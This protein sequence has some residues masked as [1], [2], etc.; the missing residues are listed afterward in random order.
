[1]EGYANAMNAAANG[2]AEGFVLANSIRD[3]YPALKKVHFIAHSAGTWVVEQASR[4][5]A[6][7]NP[8]VRIQITFLDP[9]IPDADREVPLTWGFPETGMN[10]QRISDLES[11]IGTSRIHILE[12]YFTKDISGYSTEQAFLW[13][14]SGTNFEYNPNGLG[15]PG[16]GHSAPIVFYTNTV[17]FT[18][19]PYPVS[20]NGIDPTIVGWQKSM[21]FTEVAFSEQPV[22][23]SL[24]AGQTAIFSAT[25]FQRGRP[26]RPQSDFNYQWQQFAGG[27]WSN[28]YG[29]Q[30][31]I[32]VPTSDP[33][34][35]GRL[36]RVKATVGGETS[37]SR[38]VRLSLTN[39]T[40]A[41]PPATP[42]NL[43]ASA[44][45]SSQINLS[46]TDTASNESGFRIER[47]LLPSG[48]WDPITTRGSNTTAY[49]DAGLP[50][51][52][53]YEYRVRAY[54][55]YGPSSW[56]N[57]ATARTRLAPT[58]THL[59]SVNAVDLT[60]LQALSVNVYSW[61]GTSTDFRS[62]TTSFSRSAQS[63]KQ[64]TTSAP[65]TLNGG[66]IFQ[67]WLRDGSSRIYNT[68][69]TIT[70]D[71]QHD[72]IAIYG[73]T[74]PANRTLQSISI[75]GPSSI[76]ERRAATYS[77]RATYTDGT[78]GT[79][80]A[81]WSENSSY[82]S[83]S[84]SGVLDT[85]SVSS[86]KGVTVSASATVSGVTRTDTKSVTIRN[87][88]TKPTYTL[89][90]NAV[91]G[92]ISAS[93]DLRSYEEGT[94]VRLTAYPD[95]DYVRSHW[96]GDASG[97]ERS[98][99]IRMTRDK[100]VTA[101]FV[102]DTRRGAVQVGLS[103]PL[104]VAQGAQWK[105]SG[106]VSSTNWQPDGDTFGELPPSSYTI[107]FKPLAGWV[108]PDDQ[109]VEIAG[110]PPAIVSGTYREIPGAVQVMITP[111]AA[112]SAGA[113][114][115]MDGGSWRESGT[116]LSGVVPG[117][118]LIEYSPVAGWS[119]PSARNVSITRG[120]ALSE[121]GDYGPP[122]GL[123][124]ITSI[125]PGTGPIEGG[126][127]IVIEGANFQPDTTV[128]FGGLPAT[129]VTVSSSSLLTAVT[130]PR[131]SY[132]TVPILVTSGG[133]TATRA[134]GFT[135]AIPLGQNMTLVSQI[136]GQ[137]N[138][139]AL[140]GNH[141]VYGEGSSLALADVSN[142]ASPVPRGRIALP[143]TVWGVAI[144]GNYAVAA[145]SKWGIQVIDISDVN[146]PS[147]VGYYDLPGE[148]VDVAVID[149]L[150]YVATSQGGVQVVD[151]TDKVAPVKVGDF[152]QAVGATKLVLT[153]VGG[154]RLACVASG[155]LGTLILNVTNP[156]AITQVSQIASTDARAVAISGGALFARKA[157]DGLNGI[158]RHDLSNPSSPQPT[159]APVY[160]SGDQ[161]LFADGHL[162]L[163]GG[164]LYIQ[165][166]LNPF[167]PV[168]TGYADFPGSTQSMALAGNVLFLAN[169]SGGL[170]V[171]SV[172][173]KASP[174]QVSSL[175]GDIAPEDLVI[176]NGYAYLAQGNLAVIDVAEPQRPTRIGVFG[177]SK[178]VAEL[179]KS[180][181]HL[182]AASGGFGGAPTLS[183]ANPQN[184]A[185]LAVHSSSPSRDSND[186]AVIGSN[187]LVAGK[188]RSADGGQAGLWLYNGSTPTNLTP[189]STIEG[190]TSETY[191]CL[192]VAGTK[193]YVANG[194]GKLTIVDYA[195]PS[196]PAILGSIDV[197]AEILDMAITPDGAFAY[198][199][200]N[201][202]IRAID[203]S[204]PALPVIVGQYYRE[205]YTSALAVALSGNLVVY[206]D[207]G[208]IVVLDF[209]APSHPLRVAEYDVPGSCKGLATLGSLVFAAEGSAGMEVIR[210][211]DVASPLVA[212]S[213]PT[214]EA[215]FST[216][217]P[218]LSL[219]GTATDSQSVQ[220][221]SWRSDRGGGGV[222]QGT[223]AW[224]IL[225][226]QLAAGL[227][228]ITITAEDAE[229]NTG[230]D[231]IE[232]NATF[233]DTIPPF[234]IITGP[235]PEPE[236]VTESESIVL[237]G[238]VSDDRLVTE[239]TWVDE[240]GAGGSAILESGAWSVPDLALAE[241]PNVITVTARDASGNSSSDTVSVL[242][243]LP[244]A[245]EPVVTIGFPTTEA[246][247]ETR[248]STV[249][250]SGEVSDD[251][252][253]SAI[254]WINHRGGSGTPEGGTTWA[255][256][257]I[258]LLP[259]VNFITI[260]A[261]DASGKT[262]EDT[263]SV[264]YTPYD[265]DTDGLADDWEM[266][267]FS[268]LN[269]AGL[270]T[271]TGNTGYSDFLKQALGLDPGNHDPEALP[272][273]VTGGQAG[274]VGP[275]FKYR[276]PIAPGPLQY[277][278]GVSEDLGVWDWSES[279][280]EQ[281]GVPTPTGDGFT[282]EVTLRLVAAPG[283][284]HASA[285]FRISVTA[286]AGE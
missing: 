18:Q 20:L 47:R 56:S 120:G 142:P 215:T 239:V 23:R 195:T 197:G 4:L 192:G 216:D 116:T 254:S 5:V 181:T 85:A 277:N 258:P 143:G 155:A 219:S 37:V 117:E 132:G 8:G 275:V 242:R 40:V 66:K 154:Q 159:S 84:A 124:L 202:G 231:L 259:G 41:A 261:T 31:L 196:T 201:G 178:S 52:T 86:D 229:G 166:L 257:D 153:T 7:R 36:Y 232:V 221:V 169:G 276:R 12:N 162:F 69:A 237:S 46:W 17:K 9:F 199:A 272:R 13:G 10:T 184:P 269:V 139:V 173:N 115:R 264:T 109:R 48:F 217:S 190:T 22:N 220:R 88:D 189:I 152:P 135:Y 82:A 156:A 234:V 255:A 133:Q 25:A 94:E 164:G 121:E 81:S 50:A 141:V 59:L 102:L 72:L 182:F 205:G 244:D 130:P 271:D 90:L 222:A 235:K 111:E 93:P 281:V 223:N 127:T 45:S 134:N 286:A 144:T 227:N 91:N 282:E 268:A 19:S 129:S 280:I 246:S 98:V 29:N 200:G 77:A 32:Q 228:R 209:A 138:A 165:S 236:F 226:I 145:V 279:Q 128:T 63:G 55:S 212:I 249:N 245:A 49:S 118:H 213:A 168:Q 247:S 114:W 171:V 180:G 119:A 137:V 203:C 2:L 167:Q 35:N 110:G 177:F 24:Q 283:E 150:A 136:G 51:D 33:A 74:P 248:S 194:S 186:V 42:L 146:A 64:I 103:P 241:G 256:N 140:M 151:L 278:I 253:I 44:Y 89:D 6:Q 208:S 38:E 100:S 53:S 266:Q 214:A 75:Q 61:E 57:I 193:A 170:V 65:A 218:L 174:S 148:S 149:N 270:E 158:V 262:G 172:S 263:L 230:T 163:G 30:S 60:V 285:F 16:S 250:L 107:K 252:G 265:S 233:P 198:V 21:F 106:K 123:P 87:T 176:S 147:V 238:P 79:V 68:V 92:H 39:S 83:I 225:D 99:N 80:P 108:A 62:N 210:I 34:L 161:M 179:A 76:D 224:S 207:S 175:G 14:G 112:R 58:P 188:K 28:I 185:Q 15:L 97:T 95:D 187:Y 240:S 96:S 105:V 3:G 104:A 43:T 26:G 71:G 122:A 27:T 211:D 1:M 267:H 11:I 131:P 73:S 67:Y 284:E 206:A 54:N 126:T 260:I 191:V 274:G 243:T 125:S 183:V 204:N 113:R 157:V 160:D 101:H 273:V 78:T 70:M 251:T